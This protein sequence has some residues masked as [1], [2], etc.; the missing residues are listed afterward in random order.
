MQNNSSLP[1]CQEFSLF[2]TLG[3][4]IAETQAYH[5]GEINLLV[6]QG[7]S[8]ALTPLLLLVDRIGHS[9]RLINKYLIYPEQAQQH[10]PLCLSSAS[11]VSLI[12]SYLQILRGVVAWV[13]PLPIVIVSIVGS[14]SFLFYLELAFSPSLLPFSITFEMC[15]LLVMSLIH[16]GKI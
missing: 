15:F 16:H 10:P 9:Q 2:R 6:C 5:G 7:V 12:I 4:N 13:S 11:S 14:L 8:R 1:I 3:S